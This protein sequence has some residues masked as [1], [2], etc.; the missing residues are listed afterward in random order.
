MKLLRLML[1]LTLAVGS[2]ALAAGRVSASGSGLRPAIECPTLVNREARTPSTLLKDFGRQ[3]RALFNTPHG[4]YRKYE[5]QAV[6]SLT[7]ALPTL[8]RCSVRAS[9][10]SRLPRAAPRQPIALG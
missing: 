10:D 3:V 9:C 6:V 5:V 4:A 2:A 8:P 1:V 7:E